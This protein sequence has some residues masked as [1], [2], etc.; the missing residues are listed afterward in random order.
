MSHETKHALTLPFGL[1]GV[2][3][4]FKSLG[5]FGELCLLVSICQAGFIVPPAELVPE[6][7]DPSIVIIS[8][9]INARKI[10]QSPDEDH[11]RHDQR[12]C[13]AQ[14]SPAAVHH[15]AHD[16]SPARPFVERHLHDERRRLAAQQRSLEKQCHRRRCNQPDR[17][18]AEHGYPGHPPGMAGGKKCADEQDIHRQSRRTAHER[19]YQDRG[20]PVAAVFDDAR[21]HNSGHGARHRRQHG[22]KRFAA[23]PTAGHQLV[24]QK[25]RTGH[26]A[27][28]FQNGNE[29]KEDDD[30]R[31]KH[32]HAADPLQNPVHHQ[33]SQG[34]GRQ[35]LAPNVGQQILA[36]ADHLHERPGPGED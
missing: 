29:A 4:L 34:P 27:A 25:R 21:G 10:E 20:Q 24:H 31:Q 8:H 12:P 35:M 3:L 1:D 2:D 5:V 33:A 15:A 11:R 19:R 14:E 26:V 23:Q 9:G 7:R 32:D 6:R 22:N 28:I 18:H 13:P 30:L 17:I 36:V 16:R